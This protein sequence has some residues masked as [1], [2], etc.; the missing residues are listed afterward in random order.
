MWWL[1]L[2]LAFAQEGT[3]VPV[4]PRQKPGRAWYVAR[5]PPDFMSVS[6]PPRGLPTWDRS[7]GVG[8][9]THPSAGFVRFC[10]P[11]TPVADVPGM[12][13]N[14]GLQFVLHFQR[15]PQT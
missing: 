3:T 2:T 1:W 9:C 10:F 11:A 13:T 14:Q 4:P 6:T 15:P 5:L 12:V 8:G 7:L